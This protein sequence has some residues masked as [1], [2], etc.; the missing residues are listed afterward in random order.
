MS[1]LQAVE[2]Y[3]GSIE[4]WPAS[5]IHCLFAETPSP[6]VVENLTAFLVGKAVPQT[7]AFRLYRA[8]NSQASHE[9]VRQLFYTQY[10]LWHSSDTVRRHSMYYDV[11]IKKH[12]LST[13]HTFETSLT[14]VEKIQ[15]LYQAYLPRN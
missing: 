3:L 4:T 2:N 7:L 14:S 11:R 13:S 12:Y 15:Y 5:I 8:C 10:S 6:Q 9:L 1:L